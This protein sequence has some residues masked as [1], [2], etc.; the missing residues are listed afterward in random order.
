MNSA[1]LRT[2]YNYSIVQPLKNV[3]VYYLFL[4]N[5]YDFIIDRY[6]LFYRKYL[7]LFNSLKL[8]FTLYFD[9][10]FLYVCAPASKRRSELF[11]YF[12]FAIRVQGDWCYSKVITYWMFVRHLLAMA[13]RIFYLS[14][15]ISLWL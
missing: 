8:K 10:L 11:N 4:R 3:I 2:A 7:F 14:L 5:I 1:A 9:I 12:G 6:L 13:L 15:H